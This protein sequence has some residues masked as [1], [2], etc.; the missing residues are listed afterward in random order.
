MSLTSSLEAPRPVR[1]SGLLGYA[2]ALALVAAA[3]LAALLV[4]QLAP[5]PNLS[6]I[7]VLPVVIA[8]ASFGWG[9]ALAAAVGGVLAYNF[10]LIE[11]R[12]SLRVSEPA[13]L[14][15]LGLLLLTAALVSV[16]AA[17]SRRRAI[18]AWEAAE[19]ANA[20]QALARAL[21]GAADR[22]SITV[23]CAEA[24]ARLFRAPA[25]IYVEQGEDLERAA[26]AGGLPAPADD[27][28][29]RWAL[30]SRLPT[31]GGAY[32]VD[33]SSF[34]FWP[35]LSHQ[36]RRAVVGVSFAGRE[37]G[38]PEAPDRLVEIVGGYLAVAL[39]RE[40]YAA[41]ALQGRLEIE[42]E[43][44]KTDLLAAVSHDLKTPL[45]TIL[46]TLQSLA[47]F[48]EAH[49]AA[50][51]AELLRVAEA[52][53]ARLSAMVVNL[54]DVNRLEAGAL[55]VR[56][57]PVAPGE[58]VA[59]A[60]RRAAPVLAGRQVEL[61]TPTDGAPLMVD[62]ALFESALANVLENASKYAPP[63]ST[64]QVASG[65]DGTQGWIE[66][67][68]EG[69]G[70]PSDIEALFGKFT[71]GVDGDGRPPGTGLGLAIARG[72]LE[73]QGGRVEAEN[74]PDGKGARVR[75]WA[76]LAAVVR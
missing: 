21:V 17:E 71:R 22:A 44:L 9:P 60:A 59:Q 8:A 10:F 27:E 24:L 53:T 13:N 30:A 72:F 64:V 67:S 56:P 61:M 3:T 63:N 65:D 1:P 57:E 29:A 28:A 69:P 42:R 33:E 49:D 2:G 40:A 70:F 62:P 35:I 52:E 26:T 43:R 12:Q 11:P 51:R 5:V 55:A 47:R 41:E 73:A 58:L 34:D 14:W 45:A 48:G 66:V 32:P 75:L 23:A 36:R 68:D 76:P 20:L 31:R 18:K 6:L 46:L 50:T 54:L 25:A 7:F 4:E 16:I 15:A 74:R 37:E 39:D 19:Q 38:R